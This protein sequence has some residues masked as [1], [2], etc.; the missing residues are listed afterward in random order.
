MEIDPD[1]PVSNQTVSFPIEDT[2]GQVG[3]ALAAGK[4]YFLKGRK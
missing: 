3:A 4:Y 2:C 1:G